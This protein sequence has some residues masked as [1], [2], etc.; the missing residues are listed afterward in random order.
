MLAYHRDKV[1][2]Q[3]AQNGV[4]TINFRPM[5]ESKSLDLD[6][7]MKAQAGRAY[8]SDDGEDPF[9]EFSSLTRH[10]DGEL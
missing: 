7:S 6:G 3:F 5:K 1:L 2:T 8:Q 10:H 9:S 4:D